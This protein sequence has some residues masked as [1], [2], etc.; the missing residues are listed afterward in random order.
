MP[1]LMQRKEIRRPIGTKLNSLVPADETLYVY[2]PG[3]QDFL[4]YVREPLEY[5]VDP[6]QIDSRVHFLL[7]GEP[8]YQQFQEAPALAAQLGG[9]LHSFT[10]R[11]HGEFHLVKWLTPTP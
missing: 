6:S 8:A 10:Y 4:F 11:K 2:K 1:R 7:L 3:C 5:L 9:T